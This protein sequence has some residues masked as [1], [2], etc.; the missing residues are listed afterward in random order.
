MNNTYTK[1]EALEKLKRYWKVEELIFTAQ[2]VQAKDYKGENKKDKNGNEFGFFR[3]FTNDDRTLYYPKE[4]GYEY[5]QR[6]NVF[7]KPENG[8][9]HNEF[10]KVYLE[11]ENDRSR[12][13]NPFK[14]K[15]KGFSKADI[16]ITSPEDFIK[17]W[18]N[19]KGESPQDARTIA[20]QLKLNELELYTETERF[21]FEL[22]QN[23][24]DM[25]VRDTVDVKVR[26]LNDHLA[27]MHN[28]RHFQ[29]NHVEAIADAA[30]SSKK[31]DSTKT[32][33]KGIGFKSVFSDSQTVYI[34]SSDYSFKFDKSYFNNKSFDEIYKWYFNSRN[35]EEKVKLRK[36][37][38]GKEE[39]YTNVNNIPWQIKPIWVNFNSY[40]KEIFDIEEFKDKNLV[41]FFLNIG[42]ETIIEKNYEGKISKLLKEPRFLLFLRHVKSLVFN[43]GCNNEISI[44][45][46]KRAHRITINSNNS[47]DAVEYIPFSSA[48]EINNDSFKNSGF[49]FTK[50][51]DETSIRFLDNGKE[52]KGIPEK[53]KNLK[54]TEI[55]FAAKV[56]D[57]RI[58]GIDNGESILFNYL[59]TSDKRFGFPT[60]ING[61]FITK[62][63]REFILQENK[64]NHFLMYNIGYSLIKWARELA[65]L[66]SPILSN[67]NIIPENFLNEEDDKIG[68]INMAFNR[69]LKKGID[70]LSFIINSRNLTSRTNN[71]IADFSSF[72]EL[73]GDSCFLTILDSKKSLVHAR[74]NLSYQKADLLSIES[75]TKKYFISKL[76]TPRGLH[77]FSKHIRD[78]D[79]I[80][81]KELLNFFNDNTNSISEYGYSISDL[82]LFAVTKKIYE[83]VSVETFT[84]EQLINTPYIILPDNEIILAKEIL[85]SINLRVLP[86]NI[87]DYPK[88]KEKLN[89]ADSYLVKRDKLFDI[90]KDIRNL[91]KL[92]PEEKIK[93]IS[94]LI[95]LDNIGE[96]RCFSIL[97]LFNSTSGNAFP[98]EELVSNQIESKWLDT[99]KINIDEEKC[100]GEYNKHLASKTNIY[101]QYIANETKRDVIYSKLSIE[102]IEQFSLDI[103]Y[104]YLADTNLEKKH[105]TE[106]PIIWNG[107]RFNF[108]NQF[109]FNKEMISEDIN[110]EMLK[111][112]IESISNVSLPN[113]KSISLIKKII[114][115]G[116]IHFQ[117]LSTS[118]YNDLYNKGDI[119]KDNIEELFKYMLS[120]T[121]IERLFDKGYFIQEDDTF[122]FRLS[123]NKQY[124]IE[125]KSQL[126]NY[127]ISHQENFLN[128]KLLPTDLFNKHLTKLGLRYEKSIISNIIEEHRINIDFINIA[129]ETDANTSKKWLSRFINESKIDLNTNTN[130]SSTSFEYSLLNFAIKT[131][132][133]TEL[134]QFRE[135]ISVDGIPI[136][137]LNYR[138]D[139]NLDSI[140]F[141]LNDII[142]NN[143]LNSNKHCQIIQ[144]FPEDKRNILE[145]KIFISTDYP[146]EKI[147]SQIEEQ[148][149]TLNSEQLY[150]ILLLIKE[151][152]QYEERALKLSVSTLAGDICI[153][154]NPNKVFYF[155]GSDYICE[156][157]ILSS[158][159]SNL[160]IL[161]T[162]RAEK[163][164]QKEKKIGEYSIRLRPYLSSVGIIKVCPLR[165]TYDS[166]I[167]I[168]D[169][170]KW[171]SNSK[172]ITNTISIEDIPHYSLSKFIG[173]N[174]TNYIWN[175]KYALESEIL[176]NEKVIDYINKEKSEPFF[177]ALGVNMDSSPIVS[178]RKEFININKDG[179]DRYYYELK[180]NKP[181]LIENTILWGQDEINTKP[182]EY[183]DIV[184]SFQDKMSYKEFLPIYT[185]GKEN[186]I[187]FQT[188]HSDKN[189][190]SLSEI[191]IESYLK[192][193]IE[194]YVDKD[195]IILSKSNCNNWISKINHDSITISEKEIN[196]NKLTESATKL[197][198]DI[199]DSFENKDKYNIYVIN[200]KIPYL[201]RHKGLILEKSE[202]GDSIENN[203]I[204]YINSKQRDIIEIIKE[205][206]SSED[207]ACLEKHI[208]EYN[209]NKAQNLKKLD[210]IAKDKGY[211]SEDIIKRLQSN[212]EFIDMLMKQSNND[213]TSTHHSST[214]KISQEELDLFN[215]E[216]RTSYINDSNSEEYSNFIKGN[217]QLHEEIQ[218][219]IHAEATLKILSYLDNE[220]TC[221]FSNTT[222][223]FGYFR[224]I[225]INNIKS[226]IIIHAAGKGILYLT[227]N[228]WD[229]FQDENTWII[230]TINNKVIIKRTKEEL[231]DNNDFM[232]A[233]VK[234]DASLNFISSLPSGG[235]AH[236]LFPTS[237]EMRK[238]L[239]EVKEKQKT[240]T[241]ITN[242]ANNSKIDLF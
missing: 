222:N 172:K 183:I 111:E 104:Y 171:F 34:K 189:I 123:T 20:G 169:L 132:N 191:K 124:F 173:F 95:K 200:H 35:E 201:V 219:S 24:D 226:T 55:N 45:V 23:A 164:I 58:K 96:K 153:K 207:K 158:K 136:R 62:T 242:P 114:T 5:D 182:N 15:I 4:N 93:L 66:K 122:E 73:L 86:Y 235:D 40:P 92:S 121:T 112:S 131:I 17:N 83:T 32:G 234:T 199:W 151:H 174:P 28:G 1:E 227:P 241:G 210:V 56:I 36:Q 11:I 63:D 161:E 89:I 33:Y 138:N 148:I 120:F 54:N 231:I 223:E 128:W 143:T 140:S 237:E 91:A 81:Y 72:R 203:N 195:A 37:F 26:L 206:I 133:S 186:T 9:K 48:V 57:G 181:K 217:K 159:Y 177:K 113:I 176:P 109:C 125:A 16:D 170:F 178:L 196:V 118:F 239:F 141:S 103:H 61:D 190:I 119:T 82:P 224:N 160:R 204:I 27:F 221:D 52:L 129:I 75:I 46:I 68:E 14:L 240:N 130:Y 22:L 65:I 126:S 98:L 162:E 38:N 134:N 64:W 2:Y 127:I 116:N 180:D 137:E 42:N 77:L 31:G 60:L 211:S 3:S 101:S 97:R 179:F 154:D 216:K 152:K 146:K 49:S 79:F 165:E 230:Y 156:Y 84:I 228:Q 8:V 107:T 208:F 43:E 188:I 47:E 108:A 214:I 7:Y 145:E 6:I 147:F 105:I 229:E 209:K 225:I 106:L 205:Y 102:N 78:L 39:F 70:K 21:F 184:R 233:R 90:I 220:F 10:Y 85:T 232:L 212:P 197:K 167:A 213:K 99:Y 115:D 76:F 166:K 19:L 202:D 41:S 53:I 187:T 185:I 150:Y 135:I 71:I 29:R 30:Q 88:L 142:P 163:Q 144:C 50:E 218:K 215:Y 168:N 192:T 157:S 25:P 155:N 18:F 74:V 100:L 175:K 194:Y 149:E 51:V 117:W 12:L 94:F 236:L 13:E 80:K 67:L 238:N 193:L 198:D 44:E 87:D 69:G 139:I 110:Y 59:P